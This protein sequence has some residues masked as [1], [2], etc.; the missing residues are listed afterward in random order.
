MKIEKYKK[1]KNGM[2]EIFF[3][4]YDNVLIHEEIILK[5][6]LL[7]KKEI[8]DKDLDK[9]LNENKKYLG[10]NLAIKYLS[11]KMRSIKEV[12]EYLIKNDIDKNTV[13]EIISLL[14]KDNYLND[15]EYSKAYINDRILLSNDGPNKIKNKLY[16]LGI[17]K[18][19]I[20]DTISI[21]TD[22]LQKEKIEKI[23]NKQVTINKNKSSYILKNKIIEY[24]YNLGYSKELI[25]NYLDSLS[26]EDDINIAKKE[27][28]KIYKK[29]SK[30][31]SG[32]E[33]DYKVKQKMYSLGFRDFPL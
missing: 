16:D 28:D 9:M 15:L 27:Y 3:D 30:K 23:A 11:N 8:N 29:L 26:L 19:I 12:E 24:L 20:D 1:Q 33:L 22:D 7:L 13:S 6:D 32:S 2:Y 18:D 4:N 14:K 5:Y 17:S 21:F 10:Y 25:N 31:Y